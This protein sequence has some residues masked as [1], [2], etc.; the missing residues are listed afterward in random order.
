M[1][2]L[3]FC[4][5]IRSLKRR[6]KRS[7]ADNVTHES[8]QFL[9]SG[10]ERTPMNKSI[11]PLISSI[12]NEKLPPPYVCVDA[13]MDDPVTRSRTGTPLPQTN[14]L[15]QSIHPHAN[16]KF[17]SKSK[18]NCKFVQKKDPIFLNFQFFHRA[19]SSTDLPTVALDSESKRI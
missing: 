18:K 14:N 2:S 10:R 5:S 3:P 17:G 1:E 4:C 13:R 11:P 19:S 6:S 15:R 7:R 16:S 9:T 8:T 12:N